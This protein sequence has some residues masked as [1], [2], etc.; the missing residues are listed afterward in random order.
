MN[1]VAINNKPVNDNAVKIVVKSDVLSQEIDG[2]YYW[3]NSLAGCVET[4]IAREAAS[5]ASSATRLAGM[6]LGRR[7]PGLEK[8][9]ASALARASEA[10]KSAEERLARALESGAYHRREVYD[11][12]CRAGRPALVP[13]N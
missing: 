5:V 2:V 7:N 3:I 1:T 11:Q 6:V 12:W 4:E 10:L 13:V 8:R 9:Q